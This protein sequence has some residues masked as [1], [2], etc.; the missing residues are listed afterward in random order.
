[1]N[2]SDIRKYANL[3]SEL[4]LTGLEVTENDRVVRLER[5]PAPQT[6]APVQTV[7][8]GDVPQSAANE[9]LIEISSPM[10]GVFYAAPAEDADPYV[11]VGDRV[12]KG[13][14]LCIVEAM[15]LMNEIVAETD[16]QIVEICAQNGQV[17]DF[18]CPLFRIK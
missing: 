1:M 7:Q 11:Q 4:G 13:Q 18:G 15:K 9:D 2:E 14:T 5:N 17:V 6:A 10:V 16:G 12:K 8:V 3:M